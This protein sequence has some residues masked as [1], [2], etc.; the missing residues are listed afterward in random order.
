MMLYFK[1]PDEEQQGG[2]PI[3]LKCV[4]V[5]MGMW[6][7]S[8]NPVRQDFGTNRQMEVHLHLVYLVTAMDML[9]FV[10]LRLVSVPHVFCPCSVKQNNSQIGYAFPTSEFISFNEGKYKGVT[11]EV[12][13]SVW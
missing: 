8:V 6:D 4:H 1:R 11:I 10:M 2:L 5:L 13:A 9:I 7:S 12:K 3:G